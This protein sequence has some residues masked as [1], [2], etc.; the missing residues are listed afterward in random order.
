[1]KKA[2]PTPNPC[3]LIMIRKNCQTWSQLNQTQ[4]KKN[5]AKP[6]DVPWQQQAGVT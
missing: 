5:N 2:D 1:M 4:Q 3:L 6:L